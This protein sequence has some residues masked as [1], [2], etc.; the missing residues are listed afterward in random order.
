MPFPIGVWGDVTSPPADEPKL[1]AVRIERF[2]SDGFNVHLREEGGE[3]D[4]WMQSVEGVEF[5]LSSM[6][7][8]WPGAS[9]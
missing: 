7:I 5:Y 1:T 4:M 2:K 8:D 6:K 9:S 3:F